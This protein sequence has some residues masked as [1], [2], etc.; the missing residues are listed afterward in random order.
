MIPGVGYKLL[1]QKAV[2]RPNCGSTT[3]TKRRT[4]AHFTRR[5]TFALVGLAPVVPA[6]DAASGPKTSRPKSKT[7]SGGGSGP[8]LTKSNEKLGEQGAREAEFKERMAKIR[9]GGEPTFGG[10]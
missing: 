4:D 3:A 9:A 8:S 2:Q 1:L 5:Q 10:L 7:G 6:A